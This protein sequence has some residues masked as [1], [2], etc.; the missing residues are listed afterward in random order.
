MRCSGLTKLNER[1]IERRVGPLDEAGLLWS[2]LVTVAAVD[3]ED[4]A[5]VAPVG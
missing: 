4:G 1:S 3:D 5:C 2:S